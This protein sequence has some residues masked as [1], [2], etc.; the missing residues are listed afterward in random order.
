MKLADTIETLRDLARRE[1]PQAEYDAI[2]S[3]IDMLLTVE[4]HDADLEHRCRQRQRV[5]LCH[6]AVHRGRKTRCGD[7][8]QRR[9]IV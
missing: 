8:P 2:C 9:R 5:H 3:A 7:C 4:S 1:Q 6:S